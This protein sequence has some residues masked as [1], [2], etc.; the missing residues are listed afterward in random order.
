MQ[1]DLTGPYS[2]SGW[3]NRL[4][5]LT[6]A[7]DFIVCDGEI[8]NVKYC[9]LLALVDILSK[10]TILIPMPRKTDGETK[11]ALIKALNRISN[12]GHKVETIQTDRGNEFCGLFD[13]YLE[14]KKIKHERSA[15]YRPQSQGLVERLNRFIKEKIRLIGGDTHDWDRVTI[16]V[17]NE[18]NNRHHK[19]IKFT[20]N[21]LIRDK[22]VDLCDYMLGD[23]Y[24]ITQMKQI[25]TDQSSK[26]IQE[27]KKKLVYDRITKEKKHRF[28]N[29]K[30]IKESDLWNPIIGDQVFLK[31][32]GPEKSAQKV[33]ER[34]RYKGP[35]K[36]VNVQKDITRVLRK[37]GLIEM[38]E[39][40]VSVVLKDVTSRKNILRHANIS[41]IKPYHNETEF[42]PR[43]QEEWELLKAKSDFKKTI[44]NKN[45]PFCD[46]IEIIREKLQDKVTIRSIEQIKYPLDLRGSIVKD[47]LK[48]DNWT[49]SWRIDNNNIW[50]KCICSR[51]L[52][53]S[54]WVVCYIW[55]PSSMMLERG[56]ITEET[57]IKYDY[58]WY[59]YKLNRI[60]SNQWNVWYTTGEKRSISNSM[61]EEYR[62]SNLSDNEYSG[63][64]AWI[65]IS[66]RIT[67]LFDQDNTTEEDNCD[68]EIKDQ[69]VDGIFGSDDLTIK[70][71]EI[72][73]A[74]VKQ[75]VCY[76]LIKEL[77][78]AGFKEDSET[79][80]EMEIYY[81]INIWFDRIHE[82]DAEYQMQQKFK[83]DTDK[84]TNYFNLQIGV[85]DDHVSNIIDTSTTNSVVGNVPIS[86]N[87]VDNDV[88]IPTSTNKKEISYKLIK[89][90]EDAGFNEDSET[91]AEMEIYYDINI[92]LDRI[93][94]HDPEYQIKQKQ[95][96]DTDKNTN[97]FKLKK[98]KQIISNSGISESG[99]R[100]SYI[101]KIK[102]HELAV[103]N[104][105]RSSV[106]EMNERKL[107]SNNELLREQ[108][109]ISKKQS[110]ED[111]ITNRL[112]SPF[113]K[114]FDNWLY[115]MQ[116]FLK[117]I[118]RKSVDNEEEN[119]LNKDSLIL[120]VAFFIKEIHI[121]E[122]YYGRD[123]MRLLE[124]FY[125]KRD[126]SDLIRHLLNISR[127][128][129]FKGVADTRTNMINILSE[130]FSNKKV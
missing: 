19:V 13:K 101:E 59:D 114:G 36:I 124:D 74:I 121:I 17:E 40:V 113:F 10:Y 37:S 6:D 1:I 111:S 129:Y 103:R 67:T 33:Q 104:I 116:K 110:I 115:D 118:W 96:Y 34:M 25:R 88:D 71:E 56:H 5:I 48:I 102:D 16:E 125:K 62:V 65:P 12:L 63:F 61:Y 109:T 78:D 81:D 82:H 89:E 39:V 51:K 117:G 44:I 42:M 84:N 130:L 75:N 70:M 55:I 64:T 28:E 123:I 58:S 120:M 14:E 122:N 80:T 18:I 66:C 38:V 27:E 41:D 9:Y 85:S 128:K 86:S 93:Q 76:K 30:P 100:N 127:R 4:K 87:N 79:V 52:G 105:Q 91:V 90:L 49:G 119:V 97:Y 47:I 21:E 50:Y 31:M 8:R 45:D 68:D 35:Y 15:A 22:E 46:E 54:I 11:Y 57:V 2:V 53:K 43:T 20:P 77:E 23:N 94:E 24:W 108:K 92:W 126:T 98:V 29:S 72:K 112:Q 95:K 7:E 60:S 99:L 73:T 106:S 32:Q 107:V 83:Y 3:R 69:Q 26:E